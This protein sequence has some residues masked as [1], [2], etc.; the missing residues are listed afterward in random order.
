MGNGPGDVM[1]YAEIMWKYD[2]FVGGCIW[3]YCDHSVEI[4][5]PNGKKGFT[6]GGDFGE[7]PH[8]SNFCVDGLVYPNRKPHTG[9]LEV[10]KAYQPYVLTLTDGKLNLILIESLPRTQ[11]IGLLGPYRKGEYF[12]KMGKRMVHKTVK[13]VEFRSP[14]PMDVNVDGEI[15]S[16]KNPRFDVIPAALPLI[17]PIC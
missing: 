8:D 2:K 12:E 3:E 17:L 9:M 6:Y 4:T 14:K 15:L 11:F 5:A 10:K 13:T 7:F 16:M 1:D